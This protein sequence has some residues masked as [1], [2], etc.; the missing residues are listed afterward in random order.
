MF[1][2]CPIPRHEHAFS[3]NVLRCDYLAKVPKKRSAREPGLRM[4]G[5]ESERG[6]AARTADGS[7]G[8]F[9]L[10]PIAK[11]CRSDRSTRNSHPSRGKLSARAAVGSTARAPLIRSKEKGTGRMRGKRIIM[12]AVGEE[13]GIQAGLG[14]GA[15]EGEETQH[16]GKGRPPDPPSCFACP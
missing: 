14:G 7:A 16:G 13:G 1:F 9:S 5:R 4:G 15:W 6:R 2:S 11:Q 8:A 10:E 3:Q 12:E